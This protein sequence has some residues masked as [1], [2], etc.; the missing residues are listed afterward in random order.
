MLPLLSS[1]NLGIYPHIFFICD[2]LDINDILRVQRK[3]LAGQIVTSPAKFRKQI[4]DVGQALSQEQ[5]E[6]RLT[7]RKLRELTSWLTNIE[8]AQSEVNV[9][10][11]VCI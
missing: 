5:Q 6:V 8:D 7:E 11:D 2:N 3:K 4:S 10:Y 9:A 1:R